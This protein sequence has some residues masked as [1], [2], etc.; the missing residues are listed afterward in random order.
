MKQIYNF[1]ILGN[2]TVNIDNVPLSNFVKRQ[3]KNYFMSES[4]TASGSTY[5]KYA[6]RINSEKL[7]RFMNKYDRLGRQISVTDSGIDLDTYS[8]IINDDTI[9]IRKKNEKPA[10]Y[11]ALKKIYYITFGNTEDKQYASLHSMYYEYILFPLLSLFALSD[12]YY[13]LHGSLLDIN[14]RYMII[15]G[16]DGV[17]KSSISNYIELSGKGRLLADNIVLF[18]GKYAVP[19]NCAM[20][21]PKDITLSH[22]IL[23]TSKEFM[24]VLPPSVIFE[25]CMVDKIFTLSVSRDDFHIN[26]VDYSL[27][28]L[29]LFLNNAPEINRANKT[30]S[31][32][33]YINSLTDD[34]YENSIVNKFYD[35]AIPLGKIEEAMEVLLN[36]C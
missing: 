11:K 33:A 26:T 36:E 7:K 9:I 22:E 20:R 32:L 6:S 28:Q 18:N 34:S 4:N 3:M 2:I 14:N 35:L 27:S 25:K 12:G 8:Y 24:E 16:L 1:P 30:V 13:C 10:W 23:Y 21:L 29:I 31:V 19:L 5:I 17:G 15:S